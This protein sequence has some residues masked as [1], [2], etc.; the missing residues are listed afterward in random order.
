MSR[1][2]L[3]IH[4]RLLS[5][6]IAGGFPTVALERGASSSATALH[7]RERYAKFPNAI[8]HHEVILA[9]KFLAYMEIGK[10][11]VLHSTNFDAIFSSLIDKRRSS[12]SASI[13]R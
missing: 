9:L 10:W 6:V 8:N 12:K 11:N 1:L 4:T 3:N 5:S 2:L 7:I 13:H